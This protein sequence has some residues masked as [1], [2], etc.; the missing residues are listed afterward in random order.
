MTGLGLDANGSPRRYN[1]ARD[2]HLREHYE[3][4]LGW[5]GADFI[6]LAGVIDV[7]TVSGA[8]R[9]ADKFDGPVQGS[10]TRSCRVDLAKPRSYVSQVNRVPTDSARATSGSIGK[11]RP[12]S[13]SFTFNSRCTHTPCLIL[14]T[15]LQG[16]LPHIW[17]VTA[18][19]YIQPYPEPRKMKYAPGLPSRILDW[20]ASQA[21]YAIYLKESRFASYKRALCFVLFPSHSPLSSMQASSSRQSANRPSLIYLGFQLSVDDLP[22]PISRVAVIGAGPS[23]LQIAAQL[24][25]ANLTVRLFERAPSPGGDWFYTEETPVREAYPGDA[26][27]VTEPL[28]N[29]FPTMVYYEEGDDGI[30]LDERW[31]EHWQPCPVWYDLRA[32]SP[33]AVTSLPGIKYPPDLSTRVEKWTLTMRRLERLHESNRIKAELWTEDFDAVVI[34]TAWPYTTP[35]VP[36]IEGIGNWSKAI[37]D[38]R[39]SIYHAQS[40]RHPEQNSGKTVL[41]VGSSISATE[42]AQ[43]IAPFT[44]RRIASVRVRKFI[45]QQPNR[46]RDAAGRNLLFRFPDNIEIV[47]ETTSFDPLDEA[48]IGIKGGKFESRT[49]RSSMALTSL[50]RQRFWIQIILATNRNTF[51][52]EHEWDSSR[53]ARTSLISYGFAK[54]WT[55]KA[56]LPNHKQMWK[57]YQD[58]S[59]RRTHRP[60]AAGRRVFSDSFGPLRLPPHAVSLGPTICSLAEQRIPGT[61]RP[62]RR[63]AAIRVRVTHE[64]YS[65]FDNLPSAAWPKPPARVQYQDLAW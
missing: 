22:H 42:I 39:Y 13:K 62:I 41:I 17:R 4:D 55:G 63:I 32:N 58:I 21:S 59:V 23:G 1:L 47:P 29:A 12:S 34:A 31:K 8:G 48:S 65:R 27:K 38:G 50:N 24:I 20:G 9:A 35:H 51:L 16:I 43:S 15:P 40:Y 44:H 7:N 60:L 56:R 6:R 10:E 33:A 3:T 30:A 46:A 14:R 18:G 53:A 36:E 45:F 26:P 11:R 19:V 25:A 52:P 54:V 28:P 61:R 64:D 57:D 37:Q 49:G 2:K 5:K